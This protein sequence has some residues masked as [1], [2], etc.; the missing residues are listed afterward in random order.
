MLVVSRLRMIWLSFEGTAPTSSGSDPALSTAKG[1]PGSPPRSS[2]LLKVDLVA[3]AVAAVGVGRV[4]M[5]ESGTAPASRATA[6][7]AGGAVAVAPAAVTAGGGGGLMSCWSGG[8]RRSCDRWLVSR[9]V[10]PPG[11]L[12]AVR[13]EADLA[14]AGCDG[15]EGREGAGW[16]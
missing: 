14:P 8:G 6:P 5:G 15:G 3:A 1:S 4:A 13:L 10:G 7:I 2:P 16:R 11:G 12:A 9:V